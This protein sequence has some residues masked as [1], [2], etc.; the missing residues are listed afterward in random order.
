MGYEKDEGAPFPY[1]RAY[2][3]FRVEFQR[4]FIRGVPLGL[5]SSMSAL[6][7]IR[8]CAETNDGAAWAELV[9]RFQRPISLSIVR[10]AHQWGD[11]PHQVLEDLIQ[12]TY[13]KLCADK[14]SHLLTFALQN[15]DAIIGY[16]KT[17]AVN[18]AHDYFKSV[19]SQ[20]RGSG[21]TPVPL[22]DIEVYVNDR[23][24]SGQE[25]MEREI[26][27]KEINQCLV[28]C[29]EGP[30]QERDRLIFWLYYQQGMSAKDIAA[31][32]AIGLSAK[33]VESAIFRLTRLVRER[34]VAMK[35]ETGTK[36]TTGEKGFLPA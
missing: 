15:P 3:L 30:D 32:P 19:H 35:S 8:A 12:E 10:T 1:V 18:V 16:V 9:S 4:A 23:G 24:G 28:A 20:K 2:D 21:E 22:E 34:L 17:I 7:L 26:L 25:A 13:F 14:C 5:P 36:S 31:L 11:V 29:S 6:E 27:L 33:G